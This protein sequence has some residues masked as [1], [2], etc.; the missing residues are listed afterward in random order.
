M[1]VARVHRRCAASALPAA[2]WYLLLGVLAVGARGVAEI[3]SSVRAATRSNATT[4]KLPPPKRYAL[5][6][7]PVQSPPGRTLPSARVGR[8]CDCRRFGSSVQAR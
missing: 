4:L 2:L 8:D 5:P 6:P 1:R 7:T 3:A